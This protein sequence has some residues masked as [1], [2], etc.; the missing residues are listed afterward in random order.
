MGQL[1]EGVTFP[2][3]N[4]AFYARIFAYF[5]PALPQG[6]S[7]NYQVGF[8]FGS[9]QND[10]GKVEA[11]VGIRG[12]D[13]QLLGYSI[14]YGPPF[15]QFGPSSATRATPNSWTCLELHEDGS[16]ASTEV[17]QVWLND[18]ELTE[19]HTDSATVAGTSNDNHR[20][21]ALDLVSVGLGEFFATPSLTDMWVDDIRVSS[22]KIGCQYCASPAAAVLRT[23]RSIVS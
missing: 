4:N 21:P 12:G 2:A 11:G 14:F 20:S 23:A 18:Q 1:S 16:S 8:I 13:A 3:K 19:L 22:A 5:Y 9:G 15:Y 17:R 7:A 10:Y 6:P